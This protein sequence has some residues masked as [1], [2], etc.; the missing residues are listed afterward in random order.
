MP[1][2]II[3]LIRRFGLK[4]AFLASAAISLAA[5]ISIQIAIQRAYGDIFYLLNLHSMFATGFG[6]LATILG[7]ILFSRWV[8]AKRNALSSSVHG[9]K[10]TVLDRMRR[11]SH[12][13]SDGDLSQANA[14]K[15]AALVRFDPDISAAADK[16]RPYGTKWVDELGC[17]YFALNEDRRYL[18]QIVSKLQDEA[19]QEKAA[20][21]H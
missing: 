13:G 19:E 15:W 12:I 4:K 11:P 8:W 14:A 1:Y 20:L 9:L 2:L 7:A 17:G 16:L 10:N 3:A 6:A 5:G 21:L 18:P